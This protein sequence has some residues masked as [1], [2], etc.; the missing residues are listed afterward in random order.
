VK[1]HALLGEREREGGR[2]RMVKQIE[3]E[4]KTEKERER[5]R[6]EIEQRDR[7]RW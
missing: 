4:R 7:K 5:N 1:G 2:E 6:A 3:K